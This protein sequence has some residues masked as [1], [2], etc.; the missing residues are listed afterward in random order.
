MT[1]RRSE[2]HGFGHTIRRTEISL[3]DEVLPFVTAAVSQI[4]TQLPFLSVATC[5]QRSLSV[6][7]FQFLFK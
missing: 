2:R 4:T 3:S 1:K 7:V 6:F 5:G